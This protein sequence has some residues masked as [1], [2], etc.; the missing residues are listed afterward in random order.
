MKAAMSRDGQRIVRIPDPHESPAAELA[1][2]PLKNPHP[3]V[4]AKRTTHS[5]F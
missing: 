4:L 2:F 1:F 3:E 5:V